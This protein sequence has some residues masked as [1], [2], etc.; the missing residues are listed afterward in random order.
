MRLAI[1]LAVL[2][3]FFSSSF[4][5]EPKKP[6]RIADVESL[7]YLGPGADKMSAEDYRRVYKNYIQT[8]VLLGYSFFKEKAPACEQALSALFRSAGLFG[9][10][11]ASDASVR[12]ST[13]TIGARK[14]ETYE[15]GG[16][17]V[18]V[19]RTAKSGALERV[20]LVNS[21]STKALR[22]LAGFAKKEMLELAKDPA[23]GLERVRGIPVGYPHPFLTQDGQGL[24][25][26][27][28]RFNGKLEGCQ[29]LDFQDNSW[30]GGFDLSETRCAELQAD[31]E[32]VWNQ[33]MTPAAFSDREIERMKAK[34]LKAAM[35]QRT[36]EADAKI[37]VE[38]HF[39]PPLTNEI[40]IVGGAMRNLA[41]C[42]LL[43]LG[44]AGGAPEKG[45]AAKGGSYN[46]GGDSGSG[47]GSAQ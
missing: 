13:K 5:A 36:K 2:P 24:Y 45:D 30:V 26:K 20:I 3:A 25:V 41:Q 31:A 42:N 23:T 35:G 29:P 38:K 1:W 28:L 4:A 8:S 27:E 34:A 12:R 10:P 14:V 39:V 6:A 37:L 21:S 18:Q 17:L 15:N 46:H 47:S 9:Y 43:A 19:E 40:N 22:R 33:A 11:V 44:R 16:F 32:K 7:P